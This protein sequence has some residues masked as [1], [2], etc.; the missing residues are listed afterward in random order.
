MDFSQ[1]ADYHLHTPLCRH[2]N[3]EPID[4]AKSALDTG[5]SEIG[6]SDHSPAKEDD[7][8]DWRM[9]L[10]EFPENHHS[11]Q[12]AKNG[13]HEISVNLGLEI[14]YF[15]NDHAWIEQLSSLADFDYLI[16]S[17]HYIAPGFALD[18]PKWIGSWSGIAEVEEIWTSYWKIYT[19]CARSGLFDLLAHPDLPKKF[20]HKPAGDLR[21]FYEPV[22]E[23]ALETNT[24]IEINTVGWRKECAEQYPERDFLELMIS[25]G[26]PIS[27]SS[28]AH[29]PEEVGM[30]F[31]EAASLASDIGFTHTVRFEKRART[32]MPFSI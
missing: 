14:D 3:G 26:L 25:A 31:E 8:D 30:N 19:N 22:I 1:F 18:H 12:A 32:E 21:R 11:V 10:S 15:E 27:I 17:V 23:A 7:F 16:G 4:Y 9:L 24:A 2:A 13:T 5:L 6:F 28:D 29:A 20:G